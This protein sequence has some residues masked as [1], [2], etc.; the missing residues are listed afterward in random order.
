MVQLNLLITV[1]TKPASDDAI[2]AAAQKSR[3][4]Q[5]EYKVFNTTRVLM[6]KVSLNFKNK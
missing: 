6:A 3:L 1:A 5:E 2:A 4:S